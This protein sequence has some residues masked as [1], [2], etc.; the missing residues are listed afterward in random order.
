[1]RKAIIAVTGG[2]E[3]YEGGIFSGNYRVHAV[4][5]YTE[6]IIRAGGV[7]IIIPPSNDF[8]N[9]D[10]LNEIMDKVDGL[11]LTGGN[12]IDPALYDE[13]PHPK[14]DDLMIQKDKMEFILLDKAFEKNIPIIGICRGHQMLNVYLGGT[15]Y[16]DLS[17]NP[18][19][20]VMHQ[21]KTDLAFPSHTVNT[22]KGSTLN[23]II[24][25]EYRVNS[26]HHQV[27]K[28]LSPDLVATAYSK[29]GVI[30]GIEHKYRSDVFAVQWHP[31]MISH[32]DDKMQDIFNHFISLC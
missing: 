14:L 22:V 5:N 27:I 20:T 19:I 32:H 9:L 16:Q 25:D 26:A 7:P 4:A 12:D 21:F 31:E 2:M 3:R 13:E 30:E 29:D 17:Q 15:L 10:Y 8:N 23:K 1:M 28:D 24:G 11:L 18:N 6:S